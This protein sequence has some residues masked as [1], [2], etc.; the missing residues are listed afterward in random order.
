MNGIV[1]FATSQNKIKVH[2]SSN[3]TYSN[4]NEV[5]V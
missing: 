3:A 1:K 2:P 4:G 5:R